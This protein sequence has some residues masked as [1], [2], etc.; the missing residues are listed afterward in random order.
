MQRT[1]TN[2]MN[3][4]EFKPLAE[5]VRIEPACK[6]KGCDYDENIE[7]LLLGERVTLVNLGDEITLEKDDEGSESWD[8]RTT[9]ILPRKEFNEGW[10]LWSDYI[11]KLTYT[12][13]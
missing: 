11:K 3:I 9:L 6:I 12:T 1:K 2:D 5:I 10:I 8:G 13:C 4:L 7:N